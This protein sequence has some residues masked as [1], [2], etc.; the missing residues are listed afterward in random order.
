MITEKTFDILNVQVDDTVDVLFDSPN[1][2]T[3]D[4]LP[5]YEYF[6]SSVDFLPDAEHF[7]KLKKLKTWTLQHPTM[8]I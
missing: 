6:N 5:D 4:F 8:K 7:N 3:V 1:D 2:D